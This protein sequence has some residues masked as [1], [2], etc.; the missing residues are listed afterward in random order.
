MDT[1]SHLDA[2]I[3]L[4]NVVLGGHPDETISARAWRFKDDSKF[5]GKAYRVI[6]AG[7][8]WQEQHCRA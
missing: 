1:F 6:D 4:A 3:A 8:F 5:L 7:F 2:I